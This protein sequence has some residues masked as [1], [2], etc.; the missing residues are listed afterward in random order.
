MERKFAD[1]EDFLQLDIL[2]RDK[3]LAVINRKYYQGEQEMISLDQQQSYLRTMYNIEPIEERKITANDTHIVVT[4]DA[5]FHRA[6][7]DR[8]SAIVTMSGLS[9]QH[10]FNNKKYVSLPLSG[11]ASEVIIIH[12]AIY[13][14]DA[15]P[16]IHDL[17][18]MIRKEIHTK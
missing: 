17:V 13:Q 10:F 7:L 14:K 1:Y 15:E 2:A 4:N 9:F 6:M 12:A 8:T 3:I 11:E 16:H 5:D 18:C